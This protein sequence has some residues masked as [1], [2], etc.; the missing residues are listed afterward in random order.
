MTQPTRTAIVVACLVLQACASA[1]PPAP[2]PADEVAPIVLLPADPTAYETAQRGRASDLETQGK[3]A[4]AALIWETLATIRPTSDN[5]RQ[6][7]AELNRKISAASAERIQRGD[8][9]AGR[10]QTDAAI[11]FYLTALALQPD[12]AKAADALRHAERERNR[13]NYLGKLSRNT[14]TRKGMA[15]ADMVPLAATKAE[16]VEPTNTAVARSDAAASVNL[17]LPRPRPASNSMD[18]I[19]VEHASLLAS[20]G[21]F[22]EAIAMLEHWLQGQP[23]DEQARTLLADV[24]FQQ[25]EELAG[26][27]PAAAIAMLERSIELNRKNT[28]AAARLKQLRQR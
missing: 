18:R 12:N 13:R 17:P 15:D 7:L 8:Q 24:Y 22:A 21:E 10:G 6:R 25:A 14:L 5:Y 27:K 9:A 2:E 19:E 3:L 11:S 20:Q 28:R 26:A 1:P 16:A 4:E 23:R